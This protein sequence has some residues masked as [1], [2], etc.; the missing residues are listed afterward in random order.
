MDYNNI[1]DTARLLSEIERHNKLYYEQDSPEV[2]DAEY[3]ALVRRYLELGG[4]LP[5]R[6][7]GAPSAKFDPVTHAVPLDSLQDVFSEPELLSA[8]GH[9]L[10]LETRFTVEPKVDG[11]SVALTYSDGAFTLGATRGNGQIGEN[12]TEN[13]RTIASIP[14]TVAA[15]GTLIVRGEVFMPKSV[16]E[17]L[18]SERE[19]NDEKL[20]ANPRNAAA[21]ALRQ[22]DAKVTASRRLDIRVFNLQYADGVTFDAHAES[23][24]YLASLGFP[25]IPHELCTSAAECVAAIR[26]IDLSRDGYEFGID[27]AVVKVDDLELRRELGSTSRV[28]KWAVAYKYPPEEKETALLDIVIQVGRTGAMT[29]K[30]VLAPVRLA[31]TTVTSASLHNQDFISVKAIGIGDT[32]LVRKAGEIIPE[33]VRVTRHAENS[34]PFVIPDKCP[35]CGSA[36]VREDAVTRCV[37]PNCPAQRLRSI[38]HFASKSAMDIKGLDKSTIAK[39]IEAQLV[40]TPADLYTLDKDAIASLFK[41]GSTTAANLVEAIAGSKSHGMA[42]LLTALGIRQVGESA[43]K[44]LAQHFAS[45]DDLALASFEQLVAIR[46]VGEVTARY[47]SDYFANPQSQ[48]MLARLLASGLDFRSNLKVADTRLAGQTFVLT[49]TLERYSRDEARELLENLGA[50]VSGSVSKKT[51]VVVAGE[52]AGSKLEKAIELGVT[53]MTEAEFTQLVSPA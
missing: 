1:T 42:R 41:K 8:H 44:S 20:L 7:G 46:D 23:L 43:A 25:V 16:F 12:V 2:S 40:A 51:S 39:L 3:D 22:K 5:D 31:G 24:S 11:L 19:E 18:N 53:I 10:E 6:V 37:N 26:A 29:P 48:E 35:E 38:T 30:A 13:L 47:I 28:P 34:T 21:G 36:A 27:G 50:K 17:S 32:V 52:S 33:V 15:T 45:I 49:G 14:A 9:M 4:A